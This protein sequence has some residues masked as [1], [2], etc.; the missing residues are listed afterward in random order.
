[1]TSPTTKRDQAD[2]AATTPLLIIAAGGALPF[3]V[4][5]AAIASGR[6]VFLVGIDGE[7]DPRLKAF[8]H[9]VLKWGQV[10]RLQK[11]AI[12]QRA[13]EVVLVGAIAKRPDFRN[14]GFDPST[15]KLL[16]RILKAMTGGDDTVLGH[17]LRIL[18]EWGLKVIGAHEVATGLV[19]AAGQVAGP[20]A[21]SANLADAGVALAAIRA[22]G[23]L[24]IGQAAIAVDGRVVA[25][26]AA[27]G[28]DAM[29]RR[30]GELRAAGRFTW[31]GRSG[32]LAKCAKPTQDLRIDLPTIGP[33]TVELVA[34]TGLAG[35]VIEP[36]RVM[37]AE[38]PV[39]LAAAE[40]TRTFIYA[41]ASDGTGG[42]T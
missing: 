24:D 39:T 21:T 1:M 33:Q 4:A 35:I 3:E 37:I 36:G 42:G 12:E 26:E 13:R 14:I 34:E 10:G 11:I 18:E 2:P 32:V 41:L 20:P 16:P 23:P 17:V 38:R 28:T 22:I 29:V 31:S 19:A 9:T 40:R 25:I 27:E 8:P 15:L 6:T 30:I 5:N 7:V